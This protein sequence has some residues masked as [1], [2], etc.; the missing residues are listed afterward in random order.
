MSE[1]QAT[2]SDNKKKVVSDDR[3]NIDNYKSMTP[4]EQQEF[5]EL[6]FAK[7]ERGLRSMFK[8]YDVKV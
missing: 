1:V 5:I 8:L 4:E 7:L 2:I 6:T 3:L